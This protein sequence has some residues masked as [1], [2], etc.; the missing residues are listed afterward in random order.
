MAPASTS[1]LAKR[2]RMDT[3]DNDDTPLPTE[4]LSMPD[5]NHLIRLLSFYQQIL[6][7]SGSLPAELK[8][9]QAI[10]RLER[11]AEG[12][13]EVLP[14][15]DQSSEEGSAIS[16]EDVLKSAY[17]HRDKLKADPDA[18]YGEPVCVLPHPRQPEQFK[19][20]IRE[21]DLAFIMPVLSIL[22]ER[23]RETHN[24]HNAL[25]EILA[26]LPLLQDSVIRSQNRISEP[27][28][29]GVSSTPANTSTRSCGPQS[30]DGFLQACDA[31]EATGDQLQRGARF[32][33][34][35]MAATPA[36]NNT[37]TS[38]SNGAPPS[39]GFANGPTNGPGPPSP[40]NIVVEPQLSAPQPGR[41]KKT[42]RLPASGDRNVQNQ[43]G[44]RDGLEDSPNVRESGGP[45]FNLNLF[46][47]GSVQGFRE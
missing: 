25:E 40:D 9:K 22:D 19:V 13:P 23:E 6:A 47:P 38:E 18:Q 46:R 1:Q 31:T 27:M 43:N 7:S 15:H 32:L 44:S 17:R 14:R 8:A 36:A 10:A 24:L 39:N 34:Q 45:G 26:T 42:Q 33:G 11:S 37:F 3:L 16:W 5:L 35:S 4:A 21:L 20:P 2:K 29:E 30:T 28:I 12:P 41:R